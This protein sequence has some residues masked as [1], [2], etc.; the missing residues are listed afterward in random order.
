MEMEME[1]EVQHN[2]K[3]EEAFAV[4][5]ATKEVIS[6]PLSTPLVRCFEWRQVSSRLRGLAP[7][8]QETFYMVVFRS[9]RQEEAD[10]AML[11]AADAEAHEEAKHS[12]GLLMYWYGTLNERRECFAT[13]IWKAREDALKAN[14]LPKHREAAMLA[15]QMYEFYHLE[16]YWLTFSSAGEP[17][18]ENV[19]GIIALI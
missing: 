15:S 16:K 2:K 19:N 3:V 10:S 12:G 13:C 1:L 5:E 8:A 6:N 11:Y 14:R 17:R 4:M 9:K 7:P 18:F